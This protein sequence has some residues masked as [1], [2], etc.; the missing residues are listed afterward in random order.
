MFFGKKMSKKHAA[1]EHHHAQP[2]EHKDADPA[3]D[4]LPPT[5]QPADSAPDPAAAEAADWKNKYLY[6]I[7]ELEN[8][9]KRMAK[10]R[11]DILAY[12]GQEILYSLLE[13]LDNFGRALETDR[14]ESNP[15]VIIEGIELIR[16]QLG[17]VLAKFGVKPIDALGSPFDP[18]LH[19][20][21]QHVP[22][23]DAKPGSIVH[24]LQKGYM[25]RDRVLRPARV[26][27][28]SEPANKSDMSDS[29]DPSDSSDQSATSAV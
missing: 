8:F 25:Y 28:A 27:I 5:P 17:A 12:A 14:T 26:V 11:K 23:P 21:L 1:H 9:R 4:P 18:K 7:A 24:E 19:E 10:E 20:A 13:I 16:K 6:A 15:A 22:S 2:H 29:S 3:Q